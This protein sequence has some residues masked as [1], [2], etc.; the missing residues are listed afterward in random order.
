MYKHSFS[1]VLCF[2]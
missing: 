2:W 1:A